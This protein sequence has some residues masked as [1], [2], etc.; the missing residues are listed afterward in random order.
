VAESHG[1]V[2]GLTGLFD[3]GT[4]AEVEPVVVAET[5]RVR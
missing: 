2:I 5:A 1:R 4:S 3:R